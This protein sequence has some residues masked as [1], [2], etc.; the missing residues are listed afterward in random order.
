MRYSIR[1][2]RR[3]QRHYSVRPP[4]VCYSSLAGRTTSKDG[5]DS[6][7]SFSVETLVAEA[8]SAPAS[9]VPPEEGE[10]SSGRGHLKYQETTT[11]DPAPPPP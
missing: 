1:E 5:R 6:S 7:S 2:T 10:D 3:Y 8:S 9:A 11:E 4:A